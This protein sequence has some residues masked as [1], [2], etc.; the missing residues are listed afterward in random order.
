M[1][2]ESCITSDEMK[3]VDKFDGEEEMIKRY[4]LQTE[5]FMDMYKEASNFSDFLEMEFSREHIQVEG[6]RERERAGQD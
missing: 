4:E 1:L 3:K 6:E 5:T 2:L